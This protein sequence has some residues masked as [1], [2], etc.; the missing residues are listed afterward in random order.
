MGTISC[1]LY[2]ISRRKI[3]NLEIKSKKWLNNGKNVKI[4]MEYSIQAVPQY[5]KTLWNIIKNNLL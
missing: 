3:T 5:M 2:L 4:R 1:F